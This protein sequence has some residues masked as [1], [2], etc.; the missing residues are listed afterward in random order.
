M[1]NNYGS[2]PAVIVQPAWP[3]H[4]VTTTAEGQNGVPNQRINGEIQYEI[5]E[6]HEVKTP[7]NLTRV[8]TMQPTSLH[9]GAFSQF[10][11]WPKTCFYPN[12]TETI[13]VFICVNYCSFPLVNL[14]GLIKQLRS[15]KSI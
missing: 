5:I 14:T 11:V 6:A 10:F 15:E 13:S 3:P 8:V 2:N 1:G 4:V 7:T 12:K 9:N